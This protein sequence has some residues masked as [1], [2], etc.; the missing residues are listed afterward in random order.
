MFYGAAT[1][2]A[3]I[4]MENCTRGDL[5]GHLQPGASFDETQVKKVMNDILIGLRHCFKNGIAHR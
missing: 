4:I 5:R 1:G 3:Y 2:N